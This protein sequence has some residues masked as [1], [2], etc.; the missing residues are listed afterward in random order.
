MVVMDRMTI[1]Y[2]TQLTDEEWRERLGPERYQ[3]LRQ[4][5]T[6]RAFTG[7]LWD[8][9]R[10]GSYRCAGCGTE[11][12]EATAKYDSGCGWPSFHTAAEPAAIQELDD[13]SHGMVRT[14][15]RCTNCGGH[16]GHLFDDGPQPTGMRYCINS[17]SL[18]FQPDDDEAPNEGSGA[19]EG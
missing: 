7:A 15:V 16:L 2:P 17:A 11:L 10:P 14:E 19:T 9:H 12:F 1:Q 5:G 8:E 18:E 6:E 4:Q 13:R 3:V